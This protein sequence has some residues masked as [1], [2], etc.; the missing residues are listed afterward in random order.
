MSEEAR[1][2]SNN[3]LPT[4]TEMSIPDTKT[5]EELDNSKNATIVSETTTEESHAQCSLK[6]GHLIS[7]FYKDSS[8]NSQGNS[9]I[10]L[11]ICF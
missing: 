8:K 7:T 6:S 1:R 4:A 5:E 10:T 2:T 11:K 9:I 3:K